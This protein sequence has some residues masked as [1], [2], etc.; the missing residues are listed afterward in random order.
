MSRVLVFGA[1][2]ASL[3]RCLAAAK[4]AD[5]TPDRVYSIDRDQF[6]VCQSDDVR[7]YVH[8]GRR[9]QE[10]T[11]DPALWSRTLKQ[12]AARAIMTWDAIGAPRAVA[13]PEVT[14]S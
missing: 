13:I 14:A 8:T 5:V 12:K 2:T 11:R 9:I 6:V 3:R 10:W 4:A 1:S 7:L